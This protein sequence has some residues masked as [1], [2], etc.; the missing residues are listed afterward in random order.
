M[1]KKNNKRIK[2]YLSIPVLAF[3]NICFVR[4]V[5]KKKNHSS[6]Q[7]VLFHC[8]NCTGFSCHICYFRNKKSYQTSCLQIYGGN[9]YFGY[10]H[11]IIC[12]SD[13]VRKRRYLR[14]HV[15]HRF[16]PEKLSFL[17]GRKVSALS[18][19]VNFQTRFLGQSLIGLI[20]WVA[21]LSQSCVFVSIL[22]WENSPKEL[23]GN[24]FLMGMIA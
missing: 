12:G 1:Y 4:N 6:N 14:Y 5:H 8:K 3:Y 22:D 21:W 23:L 2:D 24:K 7:V 17:S 15:C 9:V 18:S 16:F 19:V 20:G 11:L 10:E 13:I